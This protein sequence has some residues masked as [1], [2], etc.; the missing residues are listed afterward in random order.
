MDGEIIADDRKDNIYNYDVVD[1][2]LCSTTLSK[3]TS[4]CNDSNHGNSGDRVC[5]DA[6][7]VAVSDED[8]EDDDGDDADGDCDGDDDGHADDDHRL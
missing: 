6:D 7:A 4:Y 1:L 5:V 8:D 2:L 3:T